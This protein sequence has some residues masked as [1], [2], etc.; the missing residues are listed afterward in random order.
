M[1]VDTRSGQEGHLSG[2]QDRIPSGEEGWPRMMALLGT[3]AFPCQDLV[4]PA[5]QHL[6]NLLSVISFIRWQFQKCQS[7]LEQ[8]AALGRASRCGGDA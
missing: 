1:L 3:Q 8:R 7:L 6:E 2:T 5:E 4:V